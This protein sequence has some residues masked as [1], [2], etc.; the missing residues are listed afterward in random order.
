M[1]FIVDALDEYI[2]NTNQIHKIYCSQDFDG[3][4]KTEAWIL[5]AEIAKG[6]ITLDKKETYEEIRESFWRYFERLRGF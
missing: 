1:G 2:L 4:G 3:V 6:R 5:W